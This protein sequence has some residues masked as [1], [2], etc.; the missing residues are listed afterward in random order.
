MVALFGVCGKQLYIGGH[1]A[2]FITML[3]IVSMGNKSMCR[4][5]RVQQ[6]MIQRSHP[7]IHSVY[8][9]LALEICVMNLN[10]NLHSAMNRHARIHRK[11]TS[12]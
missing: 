1:E 2:T 6:Y 9:L 10:A 12:T 7:K 11:R 8:F 3:V 4:S 5:Y